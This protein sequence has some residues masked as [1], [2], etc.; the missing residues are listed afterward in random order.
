MANVCTSGKRRSTFTFTHLTPKEGKKLEEFIKKK[1]IN[2]K[3]KREVEQLQRQVWKELKIEIDF[4]SLCRFLRKFYK[5][6]RKKNN[7]H[8]TSSKKGFSSNIRPV[9]LLRRNY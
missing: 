6:A 2:P 3:S 9:P 1:N 8:F 4:E 7:N 5:K